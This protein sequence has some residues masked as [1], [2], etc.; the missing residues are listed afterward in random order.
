MCEVPAGHGL[1]IDW[2]TG[3]NQ[4]INSIKIE[5]HDKGFFHRLVDT[6]TILGHALAYSSWLP[7]HQKDRQVVFVKNS[8][9]SRIKTRKIGLPSLIEWNS[10]DFSIEFPSKFPE[11]GVHSAQFDGL[12][13]DF[14]LL[15]TAS[16]IARYRPQLWGEILDGNDEDAAKFNKRIKRVYDMISVRNDT[17]SYLTFHYQ[18]WAEFIRLAHS[19]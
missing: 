6:F 13:T 7:I 18:V 4:S 8:L 9:E 11:E 3:K 16:T 15:F 14:L 12:L 19:A 17:Y 5:L 2:G 1:S 10:K